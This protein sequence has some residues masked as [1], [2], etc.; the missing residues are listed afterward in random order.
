MRKSN[1]EILNKV[2]NVVNE[3]KKPKP[4]NNNVLNN[5]TNETSKFLAQWV[6]ANAEKITK[7]IIKEEVKKIF[8]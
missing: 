4:S 6:E 3:K 7:E 1:S 2:K 5:K 8:K